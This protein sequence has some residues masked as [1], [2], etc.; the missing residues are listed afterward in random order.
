MKHVLWVGIGLVACRPE[1]GSLIDTF[2]W[3]PTEGGT[4]L[5]TEW[6][7]QEEALAWVE[8]ALTA[9]VRRLTRRPA[10]FR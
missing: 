6:T 9:L 10:W 2:D 1:S 3:E 7:L 5:Q 8:S 4:V